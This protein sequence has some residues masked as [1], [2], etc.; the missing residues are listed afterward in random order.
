MWAGARSQK[1][2]FR[3]PVGWSAR[4]ERRRS[5]NAASDYFRP[6]AE[7]AERDRAS[8]RGGG[9]RSLV[10]NLPHLRTPGLS[11]PNGR[12]QAWSAPEYQLPWGEGQ[13]HRLLRSE[14]GGGSYAGRSRRL[15]K[16]AGVFAR[17]CLP[18]RPAA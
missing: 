17:V 11:L 14:R 1:I 2:C 6:T 12:T 5:E 15:A 10:G 8:G 9:F 3:L 16:T 13:D 4:K 7:A 18:C